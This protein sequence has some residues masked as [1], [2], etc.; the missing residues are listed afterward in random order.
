MRRSAAGH[1]A[2]DA[3]D[4]QLGSGQDLGFEPPSEMQE[5]YRRLTARY[6]SITVDLDGPCVTGL[7]SDRDRRRNHFGVTPVTLARSPK[8]SR[9]RCEL[10]VQFTGTL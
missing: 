7:A 5:L 4:S 2:S 10:I 6:P 8:K 1:E 3:R 9:L